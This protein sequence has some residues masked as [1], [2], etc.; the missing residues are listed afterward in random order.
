[1]NKGDCK[2][3]QNI[4]ML[5]KKSFVEWRKLLIYFKIYYEFVKRCELY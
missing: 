2:V 4:K 5:A 3:R 1:M